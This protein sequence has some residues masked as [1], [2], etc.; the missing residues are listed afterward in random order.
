MNQS[1]LKRLWQEEDAA[2]AVEYGLI[3]AVI[4]VA[5]IVAFRFFGNAVRGLFDRQSNQINAQ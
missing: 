1:L 3:A 4:A 5:L 2:N